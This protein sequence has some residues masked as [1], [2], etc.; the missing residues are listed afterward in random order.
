ML[1][2]D[3]DGTLLNGHGIITEA[4]I[5]AL[6]QAVDAG[7]EIVFATGRRHNFAWRVLE[8]TGLHFDTVLISSNGAI[9][10]TCGGERLRR[11]GMPVPTAL[12]LCKQLTS[13]RSSLIFTFE[14]TGLGALA[15]E[16]LDALHRKIPRWV[17]SNVDEIESFVPLERAFE[18]GDEPVQ[19]MICGTLK[20]ME[21]A[22]SVLDD[23]ASESAHLRQCLSVHRTEY[24]R[25]D[26]SIV[27]LMPD[28]CSKG[29]AIAWLATERGIDATEI[30]CIGDN[31]NDADMLAFAGHAVVMKN[32]PAELL[33]MAAENGWMVTGDNNEDGAAQAILN[34][35]VMPRTASRSVPASVSA[36]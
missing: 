36:K 1:V 20:E 4:T 34:M 26:L 15:V 2:C 24:A 8:P 3:L 19:A 31:M 6:R 32:A 21:E 22:L 27:D 9:T 28:G 16:D 33:A 12:L 30:A 5:S 10:S 11:M 17:D 18:P 35:L 13:H 23:A 7:I 25:R 29:N 14:R